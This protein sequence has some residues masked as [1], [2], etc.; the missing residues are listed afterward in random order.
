MKIRNMVIDDYEAVYHLWT[1][2][3]GMGLNNMDDSKDGIEKYIKRNPKTC[4]V[5]EDGER[6]I[7]G[8]TWIF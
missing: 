4:F 2:T 5:A 7:L 3:P 1:S 8:Q 6:I